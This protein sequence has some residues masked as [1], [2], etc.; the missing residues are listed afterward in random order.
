METVWCPPQDEVV[1]MEF[2]W[3]CWCP[4]TTS[5]INPKI[6]VLKLFL[7]KWSCY[8][9]GKH[10]NLVQVWHARTW[11]N[12]TQCCLL[13]IP[14]TMFN[15]K[16]FCLIW[17]CMPFYTKIVVLTILTRKYLRLSQNFVSKA[18]CTLIRFCRTTT[19]ERSK[20]EMCIDKNGGFCTVFK[21]KCRFSKNNYVTDSYV[22]WCQRLSN[23]ENSLKL[24]TGISGLTTGYTNIREAVSNVLNVSAG[25]TLFLQ[26]ITNTMFTC[27]WLKENWK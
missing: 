10:E 21:R 17:E 26:D 18:P 4:V 22:A 7:T 15:W 1:I 5:K 16:K 6:A 12:Y 2:N 14:F 8:L 23:H 13:L 24:K 19:L 20:T 3:H 25:S 27:F 11:L 9:R